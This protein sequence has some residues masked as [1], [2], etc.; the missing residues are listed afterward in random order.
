MNMNVAKLVTTGL[1]LGVS[2]LGASASAAAPSDA[3]RI[4]VDYSDLDLTTRDGIEV[5]HRRIVNAARQVCPAPKNSDLRLK[6]LAREC[7][8]QAMDAAVRFI[9][10]AELAAVHAAGRPRG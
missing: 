9:G 7:R 2:L 1:F 4:A 3:P 6:T 8:A 5:L 10:N